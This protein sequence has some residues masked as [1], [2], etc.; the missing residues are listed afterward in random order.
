[1]SSFST[2]LLLLFS[3]AAGVFFLLSFAR[4]FSP[5]VQFFVL[6]AMGVSMSFL[7]LMIVQLPEY[8]SWLATLLVMVVFIASPI[9]VRLF[10]RSLTEEEN[11]QA[12]GI[13]KPS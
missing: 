10:L 2:Q 9:A 12:N 13:H 5:L 7:L 8:R 6:L 3:A 4:R 1:M 11:E